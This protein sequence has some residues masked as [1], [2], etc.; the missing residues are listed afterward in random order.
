MIGSILEQGIPLIGNGVA[1]GIQSSL[2]AEAAVQNRDFLLIH[3]AV[4]PLVW[5]SR[6]YRSVWLYDSMVFPFCRH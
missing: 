2:I 6:Q 5:V 3:V 4:S 1:L